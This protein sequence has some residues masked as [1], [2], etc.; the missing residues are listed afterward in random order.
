MQIIDY[1]HRKMYE[2]VSHLIKINSTIAIIRYSIVCKNLTKTMHCE[3]RN[4][5]S[6]RICHD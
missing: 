1:L 5:P 3:L 4:C 2:T 6:N